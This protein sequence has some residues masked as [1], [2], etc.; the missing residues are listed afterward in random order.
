MYTF[1]AVH[2]QAI[3]GPSTSLVPKDNMHALYE[4]GDV[5]LQNMLPN[6]SMN[7]EHWAIRAPTLLLIIEAG[8][9]LNDIK[10]KSLN[11]VGRDNVGKLAWL[12]CE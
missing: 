6:Q 7:I 3:L 4:G 10:W 2:I 8:I 11:L 1:K 9:E 12:W 5:I